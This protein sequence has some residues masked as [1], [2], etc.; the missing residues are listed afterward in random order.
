MGQQANQIGTAVYQQDTNKAPTIVS[1]NFTNSGWLI[2]SARGIPHKGV[3]IGGKAE[4]LTKYG[5]IMSDANGVLALQ[6]L[7]DN[8]SPYGATIYPIRVIPDYAYSTS[9][10]FTA[11]TDEG[12][13]KIGFT[14]ASHT[15]QTN[16]LIFVR[17]GS[18]IGKYLV[19]AS[20]TSIKVVVYGIF[21]ATTTGNLSIATGYAAAVNHQRTG[22]VKFILAPSSSILTKVKLA[23]TN[24]TDNNDITISGY[25]DNVL[26][27][28]TYLALKKDQIVLALNDGVD[29]YTKSNLLRVDLFGGKILD[30]SYYD[31]TVFAYNVST[32][33][34]IL[35]EDPITDVS[36]AIKMYDSVGVLKASDVIASTV[37]TNQAFN[38]VSDIATAV[39]TDVCH[40]TYAHVST[41]NHQTLHVVYL[42]AH[43]YLQGATAYFHDITGN[44]IGSN[45]VA[46]LVSPTEIILTTD[47]AALTN[48]HISYTSTVAVVGI[49]HTTKMIQFAT[50]QSLV[51]GDS[52]TIHSLVGVLRGSSAIDEVI[53]SYSVTLTTGYA[54]IVQGYSM[55]TEFVPVTSV[56]NNLYSSSA[57]YMTIIA[58]QNGY[59]DPGLWG[60]SIGYSI[61]KD[62]NDPSSRVMTFYKKIDGVYVDQSNTITGITLGNQNS[63][64]YKCDYI[65]LEFGSGSGLMDITNGIIPLYGGK[66]DSVAP[67]LADYVGTYALGTGM[68]GFI[69]LPISCIGITES[70]GST[71]LIT[72]A[73]TIDAFIDSSRPRCITLLNVDENS[74]TALEATG[75]ASL[76]RK[77]SNIAA[78]LGYEKVYDDSMALR[79]IPAI[80]ALYGSGYIRKSMSKNQLPCVMPGGDP[81]NI[82]G[83]DSLTTPIL[84]PDDLKYLVRNLGVNS[85]E[86]KESVG[87]I[88]RT[89]RM[90]STDNRYYDI[91]KIRSCNYLAAS[92]L[93]SVGWVEQEPFTSETQI[94]LVV[95]MREFLMDLYNRGMFHKEYGFDKA[96]LIKC[97]SDNNPS[98]QVK[99][100]NLVVDNVVWIVDTVESVTIYL[101]SSDSGPLDVSFI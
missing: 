41:V 15:L 53:S 18:Y 62:G 7:F 70:L 65:T 32:K 1:A 29:N 74:I 63:I 95:S 31:N 86:N 24:N 16:D 73:S 2:R 20:T 85:I 99:M 8:A 27:T 35:Y 51:A 84:T 64:K 94:K 50:T 21:G 92:Y 57:K 76:L 56:G 72:L 39:V 90:M 22:S 81:S 54:S 87:F 47:V 80:C 97:D 12:Y 46:T 58:G 9:V 67:V 37:T 66:T 44:L 89:S 77:K 43:G 71:D 91:H 14:V 19:L 55:R 69:G 52:I 59:E 88:A 98:D 17:A 26:V 36:D 4:L 40:L 96:V 13:G 38:L 6:R 10:S 45:V 79:T 23:I 42:T 61:T 78:Y 82:I 34:L 49:N 100:R 48:A 28:E 68:Y 33:E 5:D 11:V 3:R 93:S 60:N 30:T 83:A 25:V 101:K 75:I